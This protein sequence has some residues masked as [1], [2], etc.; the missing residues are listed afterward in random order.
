MGAG[1]FPA[2]RLTPVDIRYGDKI[3]TAV[4]FS[5]PLTGLDFVF[6]RTYR[7]RGYDPGTSPVGENW[8]SS[9]FNLDLT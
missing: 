7:S 5:I 3:E 2:T 9:A 8:S 6:S 4:D 1:L